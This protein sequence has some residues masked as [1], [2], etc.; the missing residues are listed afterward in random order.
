MADG[1]GSPAAGDERPIGDPFQLMPIWTGDDLL[2]AIRHLFGTHANAKAPGLRRI[3]DE[4]KTFIKVDDGRGELVVDK[5]TILLAALRV[6]LRRAH[7]KPNNSAFWLYSWAEAIDG[8]GTQML[9]LPERPSLPGPH[10]QRPYRVVLSRSVRDSVLPRAHELAEATVD[11]PLFDSR[12]LLFALAEQP[13]RSWSDLSSLFPSDDRLADLR[14][15]LVE[16]ALALPERNEHVEAWQ[17]LVAPSVGSGGEPADPASSAP[18][19]PR[20]D[21]RIWSDTPATK[22]ALERQAF[23]W[24]LAKRLREAHAEG[25]ALK[26]RKAEA[27]RRTGSIRPPE[28][29]GDERTDEAEEAEEADDIPDAGA[30][31]AHIHGPWG[32]GKT[33]MLNFLR[34]ELT[35]G[36]RPWLIVDFNAWK[37]HRIRP[38]WWSLISAVYEAALRA[39]DIHENRR[40]RRI[41]WSWRLRADW[42]PFVLVVVLIA[43]GAVGALGSADSTVK[44]VSGLITAGAAIFAGMRVLSFGSAK[45]AQ[46]YVELKTDPYKPV[47]SLYRQLVGTIGRPVAIFIDDLDRCESDYVVELIE[48]IQTLLRAELVTYVVAADRKWICAA[49]QKKYRDFEREIGEP[50]RPLGYLF[51]D[52]LFQISAGLPSLS[53]NVRETYWDTLIDHA[54]ERGADDAPGLTEAAAEARVRDINSME[55]LQAVIEQADEAEKPALRAAAAVQITRKSATEQTEPRLRRFARYLEPN[56]RAMKRLVN[57]VSMAQ[58]RQFLEGREK[59]RVRLETLARWTLLELR[60]PLLADYLADNVDKVDLA[61]EGA[62]TAGVPDHVAALLSDRLVREALSHGMADGLDTRQLKA[63]LG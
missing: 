51:L 14:R 50:G 16:H 42:G 63:L 24:V 38:P 62:D 17:R 8:P 23:A 60:W 1:S 53:A 11:R 57:A 45:A 6:G 37:H 10:G 44:L 39:P 47:V 20:E 48:G 28:S 2:A 32:F 26:I 7:E 29:G 52:K 56:P 9:A 31:M 18:P 41:W 58:A 55:G 34:K 3:I 13:A 27:H 19:P 33:S 43:I 49:F 25:L 15:H 36:E 21:L 4:T 59:E 35:R 12:H 40:L 5:S 46:A 61:A 22:D 30:F 54:P